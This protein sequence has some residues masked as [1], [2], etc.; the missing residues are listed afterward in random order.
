[1]SARSRGR[2][3]GGHG[4]EH[5]DGER[6][7]LTYADMITLLMALF[8]V[9]FAISNVNT[10][11]FESLQ[12]SL[13][14]AFS[15]KILP[16]GE[17]IRE[18]GATQETEQAPPE[19][20]IP[21]IS[22]LPEQ[23][24]QTTHDEDAAREEQEDFEELKR[25]LDEYARRNG[26]TRE[27]ETDIERR[28]LVI[29]LLTDRVLFPSGEAV[30]KPQARPILS[31]IARLLVIDRRHPIV[32]EGHT[33]NQPIRTAIYPSNWE[34]SGARASSVVRHL[35]DRRVRPRRLEASGFA[36]LH[37]INTN[38]TP[39]GRLRNRRVEIVLTRLNH[40]GQG[41]PSE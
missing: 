29:R 24:Q 13:Q 20:P 36:D 22:A 15:G 30:L 38:R 16:G 1:M 40:R 39:G 14:E 33:D 28:G 2:R 18:T 35:I 8:I 41:G 31:H 37:P 32:V 3:R 21:A 7:L 5:E 17:A 9:M 4:E 6:W 27:L 34:L 12:S 19:P 11:K 26:L 23:E 10:S 25:K